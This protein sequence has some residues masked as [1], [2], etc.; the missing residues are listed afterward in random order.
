MPR[1]EF[2]LPEFIYKD[3]EKYAD[4]AGYSVDNAL[5]RA[6]VVA[7]RVMK[8]KIPVPITPHQR[9]LLEE[10]SLRENKPWLT[11]ME[12]IMKQEFSE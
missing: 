4:E 7:T 5:R 11:I 10:R 1:Y 2:E 3:L 9:D 12:D 8:D 6:I